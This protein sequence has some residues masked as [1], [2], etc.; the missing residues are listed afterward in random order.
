MMDFENDLAHKFIG[1]CIQIHRALG[2]GLDKHIYV[3][4][5]ESELAQLGI[6]YA[7]NCS[8]ALHYQNLTFD[9][10]IVVDFVLENAVAI[11]IDLSENMPDYKAHQ[12][13][14]YLKKE[15]LKVGLVINFNVSLLKNGIRRISNHKMLTELP[16]VLPES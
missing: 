7:Q 8:I 10:A 15:T 2:P 9:K 5:L 16:S 4:C 14:Q 3:Q 11:M 13:V 12:M 6:E 1:S